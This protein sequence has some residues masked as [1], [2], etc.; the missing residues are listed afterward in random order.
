MAW[1]NGRELA[2]LTKNSKTFTYIYNDSGIRTSKTVNGH[3]NN[4]ILSEDS[5]DCRKMSIWTFLDYVKSNGATPVYFIGVY[6]KKGW[7]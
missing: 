5:I 2:S 1:Q 3:T 4:M 6:G 7:W